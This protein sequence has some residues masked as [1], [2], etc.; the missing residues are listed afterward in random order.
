MRNRLVLLFASALGLGYLPLMPG[1]FGTFLGALIFYFLAKTQLW[2]YILGTIAILGLSFWL[3]DRAEQILKIRDPQI[4][5][6][7]EV[8][9][10]LI[11]MM[12]FP[13]EWKFMLAGFILFRFFDIAKIWPASFFDRSVKR[14]F[15]VVMDDV[16]A[17][18]YANICLHLIRLGLH[19]S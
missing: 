11:A 2:G 9:G 7:D 15:G 18:V 13:P 5:V 16:A 8:V 3:A 17:G 1:T 12:S 4:V 19:W 10:Y 6:I 14:G